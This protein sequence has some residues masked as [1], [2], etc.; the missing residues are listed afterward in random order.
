[1]SSAAVPPGQRSQPAEDRPHGDPWHAFGY[2]VAGVVF[3]RRARLAGGP[4]AGTSFLV[5]D[6]HPVRRG[7][8]IYMTFARFDSSRLATAETDQTR[9][10]DAVSSMDASVISERRS[11][12]RR[13]AERTSTPPG[14]GSFELPPVFSFA[15]VGV[16]KPMLQLVLAARPRLRLLL[17]RLAQARDGPRAGCSSS[18]RSAYGFVRNSLAPRHHRQPATSCGSC[19]TCSRSSSSSWST[20]LRH[21]S[22]SSSSRRSRARHGL[23]ARGLV[24]DHLQRRRHP[25]ARLRRLPQAAVVPGRRQGPDPARCWSRWSSSPTSSSARSRWPCVSSPT[26]S[27]AT[28][29]SSCSRSAASTSSSQRRRCIGAGR[30]PGLGAVIAIGFLEMLVQFLQA[31]VFVLLN[32]MYISGALA[33]EH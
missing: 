16:T 2:L 15:G 29:C 4:V 9:A 13:A 11:L 22:R 28:C 7:L 21:R 30:H 24:L 5:R 32:A 17:R 18:A 14:P 3:V 27:P 31:Y 20:T 8:G 1:M 25:E 6:R 33:D 23:R 12:P 26:C 19:P 10:G